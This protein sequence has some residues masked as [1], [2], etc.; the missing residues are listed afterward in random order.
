MQE[1]LRAEP[2]P[3]G[4]PFLGKRE[5]LF[6]IAAACEHDGRSSPK[7]RGNRLGTHPFQR[8]ATAHPRSA[9]CPGG[10]RTDGRRG[11]GAPGTRRRPPAPGPNLWR[12][13]GR[14]L[15]GARRS[16]SPQNRRKSQ[17]SAKPQ[18]FWFICAPDLDGISATGGCERSEAFRRL[19][20]DSALTW[21][22]RCWE[23][24]AP[25][26]RRSPRITSPD[27][28]EPIVFTIWQ[29]GQN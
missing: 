11:A 22:A 15:R 16:V 24:L 6:I 28:E 7:E 21:A 26:T 9:W 10:G 18:M 1:C 8:S 20:E 2:C 23:Q 4:K 12:A 5:S 19:E 25:K 13:R 27:T 3:D 17:R 29:A 14:L